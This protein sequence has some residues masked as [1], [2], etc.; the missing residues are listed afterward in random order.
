MA[1]AVS[2]HILAAF[3][4]IKRGRPVGAVGMWGSFAA[5][6]ALH[7]YL[8]FAVGNIFRLFSAFAI[9]EYAKLEEGRGG[10]KEGRR[11]RGSSD[12]LP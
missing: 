7:L 2:W 12:L 8:D 6:C 3:S 4:H 10:R 11:G 1:A 9:A 5:F